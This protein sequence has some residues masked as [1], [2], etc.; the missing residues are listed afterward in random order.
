MEFGTFSVQVLSLFMGKRLH[1]LQRKLIV[2]SD[3]L[4]HNDFPQ[5]VLNLK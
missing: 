1:T 2:T 5:K 4:A 3:W